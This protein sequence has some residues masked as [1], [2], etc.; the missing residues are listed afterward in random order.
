MPV[1]N[2]LIELL[3]VKAARW[4]IGA[5]GRSPLSH[6]GLLAQVE[7]TIGA[8]NRRGI[9]RN[10]RVAMVLPNGPEMAAAFVA[11]GSGATV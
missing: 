1:P 9:G 2:C 7:Y 5:P 6:E 11:V 8:L 10:D 4:S 3:A